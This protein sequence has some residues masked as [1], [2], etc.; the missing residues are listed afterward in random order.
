MDF[1]CAK[2]YCEIKNGKP[3]W[4]VKQKRYII[5]TMFFLVFVIKGGRKMTVQSGKVN[6]INGLIGLHVH[7]NVAITGQNHVNVLVQQI[8]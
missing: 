6:G 2:G 8:K 5:S 1:K 3:V 4:L 7:R